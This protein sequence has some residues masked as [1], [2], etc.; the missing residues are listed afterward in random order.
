MDAVFSDCIFRS[1]ASF[2]ETGFGQSADFTG[3]TFHGV[4]DFSTAGRDAAIR[5]AKF[6]RAQFHRAAQF[7]NREFKGI[8]LFREAHFDEPPEFFNVDLPHEADFERA[9]YGKVTPSNAIAAE[10]AYRTLK[11]KMSELQ[12]HRLETAFVALELRAKRYNDPSRVA[13]ILYALYCAF[14][15]F[16]QSFAYPLLWLLGVA[17][18]SGF[19]YFAVIDGPTLLSCGMSDQC[20]LDWARVGNFAV[21][22]VFGLVPFL[23]FSKQIAMRQLEA[24]TGSRDA[25]SLVLAI[26]SVET[27]LSLLFLFL[28]GLAVRNLFRLK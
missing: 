21:L 2:R 24:L 13:C 11:L 23:D 9:T 27:T 28:L 26:E 19:I 4:A 22:A 7:T 10:P 3:T 18:L 14:S 16:G 6:A 25:T 12:H 8:T 5:A 1:G 20:K 17:A 15:N